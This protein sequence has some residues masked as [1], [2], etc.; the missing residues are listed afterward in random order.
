MNNKIVVA[1][2]A[3]VVAIASGI[4]FYKIKNTNVEQLIKPSIIGLWKID[5]A[6]T[7]KDSSH[8]FLKDFGTLAD[9]VEVNFTT[10]STYEVQ[11]TV[12]RYALKNDTI[13]FIDSLKNESYPFSKLNDT[14]FT[15]KLDTTA[16][17]T[18]KKKQ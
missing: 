16:V 13:E 15:I 5:T 10:D 11:N 8:Q 18:F 7:V 12:G 3:T 17:I 9:S 4:Y 2:F 14:S 6:S 1:L